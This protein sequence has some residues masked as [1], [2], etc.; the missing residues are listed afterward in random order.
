MVKGQRKNKITFYFCADLSF[1]C[2]INADPTAML[3]VLNL[4]GACTKLRRY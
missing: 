3:A 4:P 1:L 2:W